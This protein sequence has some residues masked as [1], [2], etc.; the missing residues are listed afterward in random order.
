MIV[1]QVDD[2]SQATPQQF[3]LPFLV[4]Q[5]QGRGA[6]QAAAPHGPA[7]AGAVTAHVTQVGDSLDADQPCFIVCTYRWGDTA[8]ANSSER[9]RLRLMK[10]P[11]S[12][13]PIPGPSGG[14]CTPSTASTMTRLPSSSQDRKS[15]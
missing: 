5:M 7:V 2:V 4:K 10:S 9:T 3:L 12:S 15:T 13:T 14:C 8:H 11:L 1:A 6:E